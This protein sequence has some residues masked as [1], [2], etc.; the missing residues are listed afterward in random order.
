MDRA[1]L[2]VRLSKQKRVI[3]DVRGVAG[4]RIP[5]PF[6]VPEAAAIRS[7]LAAFV[8]A[9]RERLGSSRHHS[10]RDRIPQLAREVGAVQEAVGEIEG[11]RRRAAVRSG[12]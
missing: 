1:H 3:D 10:T 8:G 2:A 7:V 12:R 6:E 11:P 4:I 9:G 5:F